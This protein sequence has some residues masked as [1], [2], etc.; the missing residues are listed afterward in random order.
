M[1]TIVQTIFLFAVVMAAT[2]LFW[3]SSSPQQRVTWLQAIPAPGLETVVE[4]KEAQPIIPQLMNLLLHPPAAVVVVQQA[5][6]TQVES[7]QSKPAY[8]TV[9]EVMERVANGIVHFNHVQP[10]CI[11]PPTQEISEV[12]N[13][14]IYRWTDANG[15]VHFGDKA[16]S[17]RAQ[18]MSKA[19]GRRT[20]GVKLTI[21]YPGWQGDRQ[22]DADLHK[23]SAL[24]Y[25]ILTKY[26]PRHEWRQI[27]LNLVIFPDQA[28][29]EVYKRE[30]Q[31][32]AG[33]MAY[34][35]GRANQAYMARQD[36]HKM[37]MRIARHE[38]THAMM[39]GMLG[40]TPI[41]ISEGMAQYL[42]RLEWQMSSAQVAADDYV[43]K[44]LPSQ[45]SSFYR[46]AN[47]D[48]YEFNGGDQ[49]ANYNSA[50]AMMHFLLGHREGQ[51]WVKEVLGYFAINP[52]GEYN[53]G[54]FF[55]QGY[56]QG[57]AGVS[58]RYK[59]WLEGQEFRTH[60]Y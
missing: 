34:Y 18:D 28:S 35:D 60:Y 59:Q 9:Q 43:Y 11:K 20:Q 48:H 42:E 10:Q 15:R 19:Y 36:N 21:E 40:T 6:E 41:W 27:N 46:T 3:I 7:Q 8:P 44:Q 13:Q 26:I 16:K 32:N 58:K 12:D 29:F 45:S 2:E 54:R 14:A 47:M 56:P 57:L 25:R 37:T 33:W 50:S 31:A 51:S 39:L 1:K 4:T 52:C 23:E 53:A 55:N 30:K 38:M 24:M 17:Q 22:L 5:P 49:Q